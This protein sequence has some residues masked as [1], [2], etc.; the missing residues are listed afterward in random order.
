MPS[1]LVDSIVWLHNNALALECLSQQ[2][3][4]HGL[5]SASKNLPGSK[6]CRGSASFAPGLGSVMDARFCSLVSW[7]GP[8][9]Q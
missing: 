1:M 5:K 8:Q 7:T 2:L 4:L 3:S 9:G 6:I